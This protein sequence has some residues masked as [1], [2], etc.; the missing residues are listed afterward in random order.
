[1][2]QSPKRIRGKNPEQPQQQNHDE[3]SGHH[4]HTAFLVKES[5]DV[6][7]ASRSR[8]AHVTNPKKLADKS[9]TWILGFANYFSLLL[10]R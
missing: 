9:A 1:M 4:S 3:Y 8:V 6:R 7:A 5:T 10:R 2:N